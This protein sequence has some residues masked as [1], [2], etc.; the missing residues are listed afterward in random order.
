MIQLRFFSSQTKIK[1]AVALL[2]F[3]FV[4]KHTEVMP[5]LFQDVQALGILAGSQNCGPHSTGNLK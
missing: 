5:Q 4:H 2:G 1:E 3:D